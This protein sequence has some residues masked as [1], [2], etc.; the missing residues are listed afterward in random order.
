M[1]NIIKLTILIT[2]I[3]TT[4]FTACKKYDFDAPDE[5]GCELDFEPNISIKDLLDLYPEHA[6]DV[7]AIDTN[8][9]IKGTVIANDKSGNL[10]KSFIIQDSTE[11]GIQR[12]LQIAINEYESHNKY[13][14]GDMIYIKCKDLYLGNYGGAAQLGGLHEGAVGRIEEP[15]IDLHIFNA[16]G[17]KP[18][19]PRIVTVNNVSSAPINTLVKFE[20]VQ[21]S[22]QEFG[23]TFGDAT[24]HNTS[25]QLIS[26]C[27][28]STFITVRTSGY[29]KFASTPIPEGQGSLV[30]INGIYKSKVQLLI[31]NINEVKLDADRCGPL[32]F[33]PFLSDLG[34]FSTYSVIGDGETW[35]Y[36]SQYGAVMNGH[37]HSNEDW[38]ISEEMDFTGQTSLFFSFR[39]ALNYITGNGYDDT[40]VYIST[41]Y[42]GGN[43]NTEGTWTKIEG[44]NYPPGNNWGWKSSGSIDISSYGGNSSVTIA[45][46][47]QSTSASCIWELDDFLISVP[48]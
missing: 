32:Y 42:S 10:Y 11:M 24:N 39:H 9:I 29:S 27:E 12:G 14:V 13:H 17:G 30:A 37:N 34:N 41:D 5:Q 1:K 2:V 46:K 35:Y 40:E 22:R 43:P 31:R 15:V 28:N 47:Y 33:E 4:V 38:L 19:V 44:I 18:I 8:L 45:F 21:F 25:E 6:T 48:E 23:E 3:V 36:D 7:V 26:D 20:N 16:C